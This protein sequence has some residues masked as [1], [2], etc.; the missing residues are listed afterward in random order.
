[1]APRSAALDPGGVDLSTRLATLTLPDPVL[2]ASGCAAAGREL[3]PFMDLTAIGGVVTKSIMLAPRSGRPTPRMAETPSGMLNS[4]GLQG[5][6]VEAFVAKDLRWLRDRGIRTIVSIAGGS[7]QEYQKLAQRLRHEPGIAA[8][9]VNISCP[10][11]ESRGQVFA[12]DPF[13]AAS[14][15]QG[16]RQHTPADFSLWLDWDDRM[17]VLFGGDPPRSSV[18]VADRA[19]RVRLVT[20]GSSSDAAVSRVVEVVLRLL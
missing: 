1:M 9:E 11:V 5:P 2:T 20:T 7:V 4:I 16:V 13:S 6:G 17:S 10:N 14:V 19:G 18:V 12:C 15:V 8:I 3:A